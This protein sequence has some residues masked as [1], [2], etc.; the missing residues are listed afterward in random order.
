MT[1][2]IVAETESK[3]SFSAIKLMF[4]QNVVVTEAFYPDLSLV[5][6]F[7][8]LGGSLG[9]WLGLGAVQLWS[10]G[11]TIVSF[12]GKYFNNWK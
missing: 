8:D 1:G 3:G 7:S 6:L 4:D 5:K 11:V 10:Q 9:L 2:S 12:V